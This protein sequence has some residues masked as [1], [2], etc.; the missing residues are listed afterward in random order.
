M[1]D[2]PLRTDVGV[3]D[4]RLELLH[5]LLDRLGSWVSSALGCRCCGGGATQDHRMGELMGQGQGRVLLLGGESLA[6]LGKQR[7]GHGMVSGFL[8]GVPF[9]HSTS[10]KHREGR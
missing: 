5:W 9:R 8:C 10:V 2:D 7:A 1:A 3:L 4:V 6:V